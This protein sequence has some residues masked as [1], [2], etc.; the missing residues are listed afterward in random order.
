MRVRK[1]ILL[2]VVLCFVLISTPVSFVEWKHHRTYGHFFFYGLH[3][4]VLNRD[5]NIGIRGRIKDYWPQL[6]NFTFSTAQLTFCRVPG[7]TT[8]PPHQPG[9]AIQR[10][11]RSSGWQTVDDPTQGGGFC[12]TQM[13]DDII[14]LTLKPGDSVKLES[15]GA[16][17]V[18]DPFRKGDMARFV[19]F[20]KTIPRGDWQTAIYSVPFVIED[21]VVRNKDGSLAV[22]Y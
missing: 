8:M 18:G 14:Q 10:Y 19:I 17:G 1:P 5:A 16:V 4:D 20:R 2:L 13:S 21:D 22:G 3:V 15:G 12:R 9:W 7:D 6:S 11:D